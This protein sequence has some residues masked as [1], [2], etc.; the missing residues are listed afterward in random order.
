M[1]MFQIG[2][3][4]RHAHVVPSLYTHRSLARSLD[5]IGLDW[6]CCVPYEFARIP[7]GVLSSDLFFF[8]WGTWAQEVDRA[9]SNWIA[10]E[11]WGGEIN[12]K[13]VI[14]E[15]FSCSACVH[16]VLVATARGERGRLCDLL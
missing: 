6:D 12:E 16:R 1:D 3:H 8:C 9:V 4:A 7:H 15:L 5:Q 10:D 2:K 11:R 14:K 13:K